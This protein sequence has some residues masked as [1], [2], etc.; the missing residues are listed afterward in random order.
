M[1]P[2]PLRLEPRCSQGL[3]YLLFALGLFALVLGVLQGNALLCAF[4]CVLAT[5]IL[6]VRILVDRWARRLEV[7]RV[8]PDAAFEGESV[9]VRFRVRNT[10]RVPLFYPRVSEVFPPE[11]HAQKD[12]IFTDRLLPGET[13][14]RRYEGHCV[15]PRGVYRIGPGFLRVSDPLGWFEAK[16]PVTDKHL[17]K[18]YPET[19]ELGVREKLGDWLHAEAREDTRRRRGEGDQIRTIREY[20]YGD[21]L[22]RVHWRLSARHQ[23]PMVQELLQP[24]CGDLFIYIDASREALIGAGRSSSLETGIRICAALSSNALRK[25]QSVGVTVA[26]NERGQVPCAPGLAQLRT[27]LDLLVPIRATREQRLTEVISATYPQVVPGANVV[28]PISPYLFDDS[29]LVSF[30][31]GWQRRGCRVLALLFDEPSY[32][33]NWRDGTT[34]ISV[35]ET[36]LQR[37]GID[38]L[39]VPCAADLELVFL[40][41]QP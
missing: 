35:T 23:H 1:S 30:L 32:H 16:V 41:E 5:A 21:P 38:T 8:V 24:S 20:R 18:V 31:C 7:T 26:P 15:L 36:E 9:E 40:G 3:G 25:G 33:L 29:D 39:L 17:L 28:V 4:G 10:N 19:Q 27:I 14:E 37:Q 22:S 12:L 34:D 13:V 6:V 2:S 11:F